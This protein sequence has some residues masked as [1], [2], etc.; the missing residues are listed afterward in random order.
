MRRW[1]RRAK[2]R[3]R[4]VGRERGSRQSNGHERKTYDISGCE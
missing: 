1:Q 4:W 3:M 2:L